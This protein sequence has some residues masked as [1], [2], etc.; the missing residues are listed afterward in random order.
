ERTRTDLPGPRADARFPGEKLP[1]PCRPV[2]VDHQLGAAPRV[3]RVVL[4]ADAEPDRAGG[5][6]R[7]L[8]PNLRA[9]GR[10]RSQVGHP[11][12]VLAAAGCPTCG[13][14]APGPGA[15]RQP[16]TYRCSPLIGG[17]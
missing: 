14:L 9:G 8:G 10:A 16:A 3:R 13:P 2:W 11:G 17:S 7:I 6:L 15:A 5:H 4:V 1:Q 12:V